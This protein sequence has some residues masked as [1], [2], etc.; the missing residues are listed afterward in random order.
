MGVT[1]REQ[2]RHYNIHM[3]SDSSM[4]GMKYSNHTL[5]DSMYKI[6]YIEFHIYMIWSVTNFCPEQPYLF[7][8]PDLYPLHIRRMS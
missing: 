3:S 4:I 2:L 5:N 7:N 6:P 8:L 1:F